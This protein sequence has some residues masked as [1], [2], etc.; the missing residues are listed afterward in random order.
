MDLVEELLEQPFFDAVTVNTLWHFELQGTVHLT[1]GD[2]TLFADQWYFDNTDPGDRSDIDMPEAW[3]IEQGDPDLV[4]GVFD[5]GIMVDRCADASHW[6]LH[7]DF[8]Y[9]FLP[10]EDNGTEGV[11]NLGDFDGFDD[12]SDYFADNLLGTNLTDGCLTCGDQSPNAIWKALPQ[13]WTLAGVGGGDCPGASDTWDVYGSNTHG[14]R[15]GSIAVG[16]LDG[17]KKQNPEDEVA[18]FKD[19]VGAAHG[20]KVY[21]VRFGCPNGDFDAAQ[22]L[23]VLATQCRVVNMSFGVATK[24]TFTG[25]SQFFET[26]VNRVTSEPGYDCVLVAAAGNAGRDDGVI[27]PARF[28]STFCVGGMSRTGDG[29]PVRVD[30]SNYSSA[31]FQV[32]VVAPVEIYHTDDNDGIIADNHGGCPNESECGGFGESCVPDETVGLTGSG[33]SFAAPQVAGVAALVRSRFPNLNQFEV[34]QRLRRSAEFYW[35]GTRPHHEYGW[36]KV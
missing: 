31:G 11:L 6:R 13:D 12:N 15:V 21:N 29:G 24:A 7:S 14:T 16:K 10:D 19:I 5:S 25:R 33:T 34:K 32:D 8:N 3:A 1:P 36:G 30:Y 22:A 27:Y 20:C 4:V 23:Y 2:S 9:F 17:L 35:S 28:D 18:D 26:A